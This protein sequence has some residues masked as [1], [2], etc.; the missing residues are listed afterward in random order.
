MRGET[1]R[2]FDAT[3]LFCPKCKRAVPV[4]KRLLLILSNGDKYDYMCT[5]CGTSVGDKLVSQQDNLRA[6][7]K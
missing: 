1:Y 6:I 2:D 4:R 3:E 5:F 7:I